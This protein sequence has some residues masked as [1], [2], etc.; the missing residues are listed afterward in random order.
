MKMQRSCLTRLVV[1]ATWGFALSCSSDCVPVNSGGVVVDVIGVSS[2]DKLSITATDGSSQY[3]FDATTVS[4]SDGGIVCEFQGLNGHPGTFE[5]QLTID[6]Q[7]TASQSVTLDKLDEC[8]VS[9]KSV[10]FVANPP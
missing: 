2:C 3:P 1:L 9:A 8:N 6:G 4:G 7:P 5:L 10:T